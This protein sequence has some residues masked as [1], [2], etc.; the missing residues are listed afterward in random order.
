[1][2]QTAAGDAGIAT[3]LYHLSRRAQAMA[4]VIYALTDWGAELMVEIADADVFRSHWL[5]LPTERFLTDHDPG[6]PSITIDVHAGDEPMLIE[7]GDGPS[8]HAREAPMT[9]TR[10]SSE[11]PMWSS[12]SSAARSVSASHEHAA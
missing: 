4:P 7:T 1:M 11:R 5:S 6:G 12:L 9:P 2:S 3:T 8:T 10:S